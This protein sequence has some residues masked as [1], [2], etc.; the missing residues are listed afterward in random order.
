MEKE[1]KGEDLGVENKDLKTPASGTKRK[2][3]SDDSD[4]PVKKS[5]ISSE[6]ADDDDDD[7][8]GEED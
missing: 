8:E 4:T 7:G 2:A 5:K 6:S 1:G 3:P